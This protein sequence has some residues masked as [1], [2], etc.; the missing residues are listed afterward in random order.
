MVDRYFERTETESHSTGDTVAESADI[1]NNQ[2]AV[3]SLS[4]EYQGA[5]YHDGTHYALHYDGNDMVLYMGEKP[6]LLSEEYR[7]N[8]TLEHSKRELFLTSAGSLLVALGGVVYRSTDGGSSW[9]THSISLPDTSSLWSISEDS[10]GNIFASQS[11]GSEVALYKSTDD[12]QS[13]TQIADGTTFSNFP[14]HVHRVRVHP[15]SDYVIVTGGDDPGIDGYYRSTDAGSSWDFLEPNVEGQWVGI[16][17]HPTDGNI[18]FIGADGGGNTP[19]H[20][21]RVSDNGNSSL[22]EDDFEI[23]HQMNLDRSSGAQ[24]TFEIKT[25]YDGSEGYYL[26]TAINQKRNL[27]WASD[28]LNGQFWR[29]IGTAQGTSESV[30]AGTKTKATAETVLDPSVVEH[31]IEG[32]RAVGLSPADDFHYGGL[33]AIPA[34]RRKTWNDIEFGGRQRNH[35]LVWNEV[36]DNTVLA[37]VTPTGGD[38]AFLRAYT[39]QGLLIENRNSNAPETFPFRFDYENAFAQFRAYARFRSGYGFGCV[40]AEDLSGKTG[41]FDGE[42]RRDDGTNTADGNPANC[43]WDNAAGVWRVMRTDATFS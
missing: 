14:T 9:S 4:R 38:N 16:G 21:V 34:D 30:Y 42:I 32:E 6:W 17:L 33:S 2:S 8:G 36:D 31:A 39:G 40:D 10:N 3:R 41:N 18:Y 35:R 12:G 11:S 15:V 22:N 5:V 28:T 43:E 13:W 23:V 26:A 20:I 24:G 1:R 25:V 19:G 29:A 7:W 27:I 37:D